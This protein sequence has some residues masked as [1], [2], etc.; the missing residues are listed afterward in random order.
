MLYLI[1]GARSQ[2]AAPLRLWEFDLLPDIRNMKEFWEIAAH[3][4]G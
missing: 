1:D 2:S 3:I 4:G